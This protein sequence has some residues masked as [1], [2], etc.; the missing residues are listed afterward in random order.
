MSEIEIDESN[1]KEDGKMK[2][3][4]EAERRK[5][6]FD[7]A[8]ASLLR[9]MSDSDLERLQHEHY[10]SYDYVLVF[11]MKGVDQSEFDPSRP[12]EGEQSTVAKH[13]IKSMV[14]AGFV[15]YTFLSV[16][17][18][19]LIVLSS[20][21]SK[22]LRNF[23]DKTGYMLQLGEAKIRN[24]LSIGNKDRRIKPVK[25]ADES[26]FSTLR[27]YQYIYGEFSLES[28]KANKGEVYQTYHIGQDLDCIFSPLS[29]LKLGFMALQAPRHLQG[30]KVQVSLL[31]QQ[32]EIKAIFPLHRSDLAEFSE[33]RSFV[34]STCSMPWDVPLL[35]VRDYFG[36]RSALFYN[37]LTVQSRA[38]ILP[39]VV[40]VAFQLIVWSTGPNY[41]HPSICFFSV[42]ICLWGVWMI[43]RY[44]RTEARKAMEWGMTEFEVKE[45]DRP[46]FRGMT[47]ASPEDGKPILYFPVEDKRKMLFLSSSV[48]YSC[49]LV[50]LGSVAGI[51][52]IRS[53]LEQH[54][55]SYAST[56]ASFLSTVQIQVLNM[57][58]YRIAKVMN[59]RENHKT[60]TAFQD[61]LILKLF[62]FQFINSYISFFYVAYIAMWL[63][64]GDDENPNFLGQCGFYNCMEPLSWNLA[65]IYGSRITV[66]NIVAIASDYYYYLLKNYEETAG[67]ATGVYIPTPEREYMLLPSDTLMDNLELFSDVAVQF[68]FTM[69]FSAALPISLAFTLLSNYLRVKLQLW[70]SIE[71]KQRPIP[72]GAQDIGSWSY[73]LYFICILSVV[74][75]GAIICFTMDTLKT[76][77]E[78]EPYEQHMATPPDSYR[79][80]QFS[81]VGRLW[82]WFGFI[83]MCWVLQSIIS[84]SPNE[85]E[86]VTLQGK[87]RKFIT[88]KLVHLEADEDYDA[89]DEELL[90]L[91]I[92]DEQ[93]EEPG[94]LRSLLGS[95]EASGAVGVKISKKR[96]DE[97]PILGT[98]FSVDEIKAPI[99][100]STGGFQRVGPFE[101]KEGGPEAGEDKRKSSVIFR[102]GSTTAEYKES[103]DIEMTL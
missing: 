40:G 52:L 102:R 31:K 75:N 19:E 59:E 84:A 79:R 67:V 57:A 18:D 64:T 71:L 90:Q 62:L 55:G 30:C 17:Q 16:Q 92:E 88:S 86:E 77:A 20:L 103:N 98:P 95:S 47:I 45:I 3:K 63:P 54:V 69:L 38:L 43:K 5:K 48:V 76:D 66:D 87:R 39:S 26:R 24:F 60:D 101:S 9:K 29:R 72:D 11:P 4:L 21:D 12:E 82:V 73:I 61:A 32:G 74:T 33:I 89:D 10:Y 41:S 85:D 49:I 70:K 6:Y 8:N 27:P 37:F 91:T 23:A 99:S 28:I 25:I 42:F 7:E 22:A 81:I 80:A 2:R 44:K 65:I 56:V 46:E 68:G 53:A 94:C 14:E 78:V 93:D 15:I 1:P 96:L 34:E 50:V 13:V 36:E 51:Y 83:A 97:V 35:A 58:Y 100:A